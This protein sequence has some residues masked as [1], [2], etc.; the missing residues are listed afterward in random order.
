MRERKCE[1]GRGR[2]GERERGRERE[3]QASST[4]V[5]DEPEAGLELTNREIM[6]GAEVGCLTD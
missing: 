3:S 5:S 6:A 4:T 1:W 2:E